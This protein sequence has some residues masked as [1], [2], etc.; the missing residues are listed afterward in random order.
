M[1]FF[2]S[3]IYL[4]FILL[5]WLVA[6]K[7]YAQVKQYVKIAQLSH[8]PKA[9]TTVYPV[10][11]PA[12]NSEQIDM[13][14]SWQIAYPMLSFLPQ[15][16]PSSKTC[17]NSYIA[18]INGKI[19]IYNT[20]PHL[21][22]QPKSKDDPVIISQISIMDTLKVCSYQQTQH[23]TEFYKGYTIKKLPKGNYSTQLI[24]NHH[25][26]GQ[27][28]YGKRQPQKTK[29]PKHP[30]G[31]TNAKQSQYLHYDSLITNDHALIYILEPKKDSSYALINYGKNVL[32]MD[33]NIVIAIESPLIHKQSSYDMIFMQI[34]K[35]SQSIPIDPDWINSNTSLS[36]DSTKKEP[37]LIPQ[38]HPK[39]SVIYLPVS[40]NSFLPSKIIFAIKEI[41]SK[42]IL[43]KQWFLPLKDHFPI[44]LHDSQ[45]AI[46]LLHYILDKGKIK[47]LKRNPTSD[48]WHN[49][50]S[51]WKNQDPTPEKLYNELMIEYYQRVD[52]SAKLFTSAINHGLNTD[53]GTFYITHG[54]PNKRKRQTP[55]GRAFEI[56]DYPNMTV[57]FQ[58]KSGFG[59]YKLIHIKPKK[60]ID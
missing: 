43:L 45:L 58:A 35:S 7:S 19:N 57:T 51:F 59:E 27:I 38:Y 5:L 6:G 44:G 56:W 22:N 39:H 34:S 29:K 52:G 40:P 9:Y 46:D 13:L 1:R 49:L 16:S 37:V 33:R 18:H 8:I 26:N 21:N 14:I 55:P 2:F 28:Q 10:N 32:P 41:Q 24:L 23:K 60:N 36:V 17:G 31:K 48:E 50:I 25:K 42:K 11:I 12:S 3:T 47:D 20:Y 53:R 15:S 4:I 54:A 30:S